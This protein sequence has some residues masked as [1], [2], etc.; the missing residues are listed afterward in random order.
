MF[1]YTAQPMWIKRANLLPFIHISSLCT[2][3]LELKTDLCLTTNA[4]SKSL[5]LNSFL[6]LIQFEG[7]KW[8]E[9]FASSIEKEK[10]AVSNFV[11]RVYFAFFLLYYLLFISYI[12]ITFIFQF[13]IKFRRKNI[14]FLNVRK[15]FYFR[16]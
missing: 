13:L 4:R 3:H 14:F 15:I 9:H 10:R 16:I 11:F 2:V 5:R 7:K 6:L 8:F 12:C 1:L